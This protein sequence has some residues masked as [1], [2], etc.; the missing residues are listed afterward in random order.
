[1]RPLRRKDRIILPMQLDSDPLSSMFYLQSGDHL[2][3]HLLGGH[4]ITGHL[5]VD[6]PVLLLP[7]DYD[8]LLAMGRAAHF[9]LLTLSGQG[10]VWIGRDHRRN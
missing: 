10:R 2:L 8:G 1:M 4:E 7:A 3:S 5:R 9:F 6:D